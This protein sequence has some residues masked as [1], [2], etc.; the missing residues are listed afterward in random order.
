[1]R[2]DCQWGRAGAALEAD[3][4]IIVD[5]LS[6]STSVV[7]A[8][9]RGA[10]VFPFHGDPAALA[11]LV[12]ARPASKT[13]SLTEPSLSPTSMSR[14][15]AG[16]GIVMPSP[17]GARCSLGA[18]AHHVFCGSL[19]NASAVAALAAETGE[20]ILVI[21]AGEMWPDGS[22][23]VAFEDF[24]G[25]GAIIA[26]LDGECTPEAQ[27]AVATFEDAKT[28]LRDRLF[29][30]PSGT[31][32]IERGFAEDVELAAQL[33]ASEAVPMLMLHRSRY[34]DIAPSPDL[35]D[36]RIRY[37]ERMDG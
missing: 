34:R 12:G 31:E 20:R 2:I 17:N 36:K 19:R 21:P 24:A 15:S 35:A 14:L 7:I 8:A 5:V 13:R 18:A 27:A 25:A 1:M 29:A 30:C 33:D 28:D 23:R 32:L 37:Y 9:E 26:R 10:R 6:F 16:E 22:M 11:Q 3:V 4:A